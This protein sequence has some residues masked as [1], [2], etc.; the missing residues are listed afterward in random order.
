MNDLQR[1]SVVDCHAAVA[2]IEGFNDTDGQKLIP[3]RD[4]ADENLAIV[5]H[6]LLV[7]DRQHP[8]LLRLHD[9]GEAARKIE[10]RLL[11]LVKALVVVLTVLVLAARAHLGVMAEHEGQKQL[12]EL[13]A[14]RILLGKE[15]A[16][17]RVM[18]V[19]VEIDGVRQVVQLRPVILVVGLGLGPSAITLVMLAML[20]L[21]FFLYPF[22]LLILVVK[23]GIFHLESRYKAG[24]V[25]EKG[26]LGAHYRVDLPHRL[27]D[28]ELVVVELGGNQID[29]PHSEV[30]VEE[31]DCFHGQLGQVW[32]ILHKV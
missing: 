4:P 28:L 8:L 7:L 18:K 1:A 17:V 31:N 24:I 9:V 2:L 23:Y 13:L 27:H 21:V 6:F 29:V 25:P 22:V 20:A 3:D 26:T 14:V 30:S 32:V 12:L 19:L 15:R 16:G 10:L 11:L 5:R